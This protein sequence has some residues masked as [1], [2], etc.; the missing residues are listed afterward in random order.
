MGDA[1]VLSIAS[2]STAARAVSSD[3]AFLHGIDVLQRRAGLLGRH[4]VMGEL[5]A[6][7]RMHV[8]AR[9]DGEREKDHDEARTHEADDRSH[10]LTVLHGT[11]IRPGAFSAPCSE[12][13]VLQSPVVCDAT[14]ARVFP[15]E[16]TFAVYGVAILVF[17]KK[18]PA[19]L[20]GSE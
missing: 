17:E 15:P 18:L 4:R 8:R 9:R 1:A 7:P 14:I 16:M 2:A 3:R 11:M 13:Q 12:W 10:E 5:R 19:L 6:L 20:T